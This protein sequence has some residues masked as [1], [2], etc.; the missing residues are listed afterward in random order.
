M[1]SNKFLSTYGPEIV[2]FLG[3]WIFSGACFKNFNFKFIL[4]YNKF[5][6]QPDAISRK[7]LIKLN[8]AHNM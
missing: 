3:Y 5:R 8:F 4:G 6:G 2:L 1:L 7:Y